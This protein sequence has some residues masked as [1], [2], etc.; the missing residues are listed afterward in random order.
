MVGDCNLTKK[1]KTV[2]TKKTGS[3]MRLNVNI[4]YY[5]QTTCSQVKRTICTN[6]GENLEFIF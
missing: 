6:K 2:N 3:S 5:M 1:P 4:L